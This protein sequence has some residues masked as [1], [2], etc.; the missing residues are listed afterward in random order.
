GNWRQGEIMA[1]ISKDSRGEPATVSVIPN[2]NF[3]SVSNFRYYGTRDRLPLQF[4][5]AWDGEPIGIEYM[6]LKTGAV[7][8][9][10]TAEK[11]RR[12]AERL[13]SDGAL[14]RVFP[15][16]GEFQLPDGSTATLRAR[17]LSEDVAAGRGRGGGARRFRA[18]GPG[19]GP[20]RARRCGDRRAGPRD[21]PEL[22][23]H[24]A[25]R[26]HRARPDPRSGGAP[27]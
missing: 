23:R 20:P 14:A 12:I 24:A 26:P 3:F 16:V 25:A 9:S 4:T 19:G 11:P 13:Q 5:R 22:R 10:W 27:G 17:R 2:D 6:V 7:G 15:V 18:G 8:P 21:R 1:I